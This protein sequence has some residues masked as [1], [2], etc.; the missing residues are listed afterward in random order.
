MASSQSAGQ[1]TK[2]QCGLDLSG[3][4][5]NKEHQCLSNAC[6]RLLPGGPCSQEKA[7]EKAQAARA[8]SRPGQT[9]GLNNAGGA[10]GVG[11]KGKPGASTR[12]GG[13]PRQALNREP[14]PPGARLEQEK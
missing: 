14:P 2:A 4:D 3:Q 11:W 10:A 12:A 8:G 1:G 9:P 5:S 7:Q 13:V 6:A